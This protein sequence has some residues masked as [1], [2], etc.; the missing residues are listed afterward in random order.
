MHDC[1]LLETRLH[2]CFVEYSSASESCV[3][4]WSGKVSRPMKNC[5]DKPQ[6]QLNNV[7]R[8]LSR[9]GK[10]LVKKVANKTDAR[11]E[12]LLIL[13]LMACE[14]LMLNYCCGH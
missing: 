3:L 1:D 7:Y 14:R 2:E 6:L 8:Q 5:S 4:T 10:Q 13:C 12:C 11:R 9:K